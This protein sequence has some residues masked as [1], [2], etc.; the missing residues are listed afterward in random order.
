MF[1]PDM[2]SF[3]LGD[4]GYTSKMCWLMVPYAYKGDASRWEKRY[5]KFHSQTRIV[6][7]QA[8]GMLKARFRCLLKRLDTKVE[9]STDIILACMILHNV[10]V[11]A[12]E[13]FFAD[14]W[15]SIMLYDAAERRVEATVGVLRG[16]EDEGEEA[17]AAMLGEFRPAEIG[18]DTDDM[19]VEGVR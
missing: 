10:C 18:R 1:P 19:E 13:M 11:D 15:E 6:I 5:N 4:S 17:N 8:F 2:R 9:K 12:K 3:V 7:E 16:E 14:W